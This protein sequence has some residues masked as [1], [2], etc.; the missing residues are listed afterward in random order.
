MKDCK[1]FKNKIAAA[2]IVD[3]MDRQN[4]TSAQI[5]FELTKR[6]YVLNGRSI[7]TDNISRWRAPDSLRRV[8]L[9]SKMKSLFDTFIE[10]EP[11]KPSSVRIKGFA[12]TQQEVSAI[13]SW[14]GSNFGLLTSES[15]IRKLVLYH[16][17]SKRIQDIILRARE[18]IIDNKALRERGVIVRT[19]KAQADQEQTTIKDQLN[20]NLSQNEN[21]LEE[22]KEKLTKT[23]DALSLALDKIEQQD[24]MISILLDRIWSGTA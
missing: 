21:S 13:N 9:E 23:E 6:G 8:D 20:L 24:K 22:I 7:S 10:Q 4:K 2:R 12:L 14:L 1:V 5:V 11:I 17:Q 16:Y 3:E 18:R 15:S 19:T